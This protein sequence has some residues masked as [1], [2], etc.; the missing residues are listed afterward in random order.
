MHDSDSAQKDRARIL[1][2][3]DGDR[4]AFETVFRMY[5]EPLCDFV[6]GYVG[7]PEVAEELVQDL[8]LELWIQRENWDVQESVRSYL[9]AAARNRALDHL[10]HQQVVERWEEEPRRDETYRPP[11]PLDELQHEQLRTEVQRAIK[12]LSERRRVVFVLSRR[13]GLTYKEIAV[14]LD[15]SVRTIETHMREALK[16]LR[17]LLSAHH[18]DSISG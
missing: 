4:A 11:S 1:K 3:R 17:D 6:Q 8:F 9:Y 13:H 7:S 15:L 14:M 16:S 10:K 18:T 2:I 12:Q 5:A